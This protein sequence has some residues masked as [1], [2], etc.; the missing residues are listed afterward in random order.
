MLSCGLTSVVDHNN[1]IRESHNSATQRIPGL[2]PL[3]S[4]VK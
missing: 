3:I 4:V 1:M 2:Q